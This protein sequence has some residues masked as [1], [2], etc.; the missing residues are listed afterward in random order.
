LLRTG[1]QV[2]AVDPHVRETAPLDARVRRV[3]LTEEELA[4]ADAVVLLTDH[5][6]FDYD[7][8]LRGA[9]HVLDCRRRLRP[10]VN[11]E[12]L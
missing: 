6:D 5:D 10:A 3:E 2:H 7:V 11:V 9:Q 1:A 4:A 8:V 12:I